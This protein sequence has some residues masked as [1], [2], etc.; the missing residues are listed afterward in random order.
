LTVTGGPNAGK[1]LSST[2]E[3]D[4][5]PISVD[6]ESLKRYATDLGK[7]ATTLQTVATHVKQVKGVVEPGDFAEADM[8]RKMVDEFAAACDA[9]LGSLHD[10]FQHL[11]RAMTFLAEDVT[12]AER[13]RT[14]DNSASSLPVVH[15]GQKVV[16]EVAAMRPATP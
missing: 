3:D 2:I 11:S 7:V 5:P 8:V 10:G 12:A 13:Q 4:R 16:R 15:P 1:P 9:Q 6:P 14:A